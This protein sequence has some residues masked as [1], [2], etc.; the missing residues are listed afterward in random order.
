MIEQ[1][2]AVTLPTFGVGALLLA[3]GARK[4]SAANMRARWLKFG[5][6]FVI[7]HAVLAAAAAGRAWIA[8]LTIAIVLLA[9]VELARAWRCISPPRPS[10]IWIVYAAVAALAVANSLALPAATLAFIFVVAASFDGFSQAVGQWLGRTPLAPRVSPAKTVEGLVGG[11]VGAASIA[12]A[13]HAVLDTS[14]WR[15]AAWGVATSGAAVAG[16]LSKS[17][18]KRR[19]GLKD[20]ADT[21]PG[22]G[23]FLDRFDSF[24]AASGLVGLAMRACA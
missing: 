6:F 23:G 8:A 1:L 22:H 10:R 18:V 21:L 11:L 13:V 7:V 15:A 16:D 4:A 19:A 12:M 5:V 20:F 17:W 9:T 24:L 2:L 14:V 3:M